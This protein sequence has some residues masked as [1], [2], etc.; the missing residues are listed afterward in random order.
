MRA[1]TAPQTPPSSARRKLKTSPELAR[2][3]AAPAIATQLQPAMAPILAQRGS[4]PDAGKSLPLDFGEDRKVTKDLSS[5]GG[6]L[7][8]CPSFSSPVIR[9]II[10][11]VPPTMSALASVASGSCA[12]PSGSTKT[13]LSVMECAECVPELD[14]VNSYL[15]RLGCLAMDSAMSSEFFGRCYSDIWRNGRIRGF[16]P[17]NLSIVQ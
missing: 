16:F 10:S 15:S 8:F 9:S 5:I 2:M 17:T 14:Q 13:V 3:R 1:E 6:Y 11:G 12:W 4:G 7:S